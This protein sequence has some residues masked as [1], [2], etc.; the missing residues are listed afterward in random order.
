M[1]I[2]G[3]IVLGALAGFIA[4]KIV[5]KHGEGVALDTVLGVVGAVVGGAVFHIIGQVG[6]TGFNISSM[7][8]AVIG[9]VL[10][11]AAYHAFSGHRPYVR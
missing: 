7:F 4:S 8:V 1:S 9:A 3:W 2:I 11:L 6:M 10:V 5:N